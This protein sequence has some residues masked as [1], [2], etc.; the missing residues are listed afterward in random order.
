MV[1][2]KAGD[3]TVDTFIGVATVGQVSSPVMEGRVV[4]TTMAPLNRKAPALFVDFFCKNVG[5]PGT[6]IT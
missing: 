2:D 1:T 6:V 5:S 3:G 4:L